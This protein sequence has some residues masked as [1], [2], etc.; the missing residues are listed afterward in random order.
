[1]NRRCLNCM[2]VFQ[3]PEEYK[4][5]NCVC[6]FC[7]F[8][9]NT[10]P[11][12]ATH[13]PPGVVINDRYEIGTVLGAGGFGITYRTWDRVL[14]NIVCVKEYFP[15]GVA[16]RTETVTVSALTAQ[17]AASFERG[18]IR[19]LNEARNLARFNSLAGTVSIYDFFEANGTAYI[20]ME[21]LEG[22]NIKPRWFLYSDL[23]LYLT[24]YPKVK[25]IDDNGRRVKIDNPLFILKNRIDC[26]ISIWDGGWDDEDDNNLYRIVYWIDY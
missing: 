8:V 1:M 18:K 3:V 16:T 11:T 21:Y 15:K 26:F 10:P 25:D 2:H 6:P 5:R 22:C 24:K 4:N 20:V 17:E 9:E 12:V 23:L 14:N 13:L 7:G 19:F